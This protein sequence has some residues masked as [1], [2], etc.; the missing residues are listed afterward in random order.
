MGTKL[1]NQITLGVFCI[2]LFGFLLIGAWKL[3]R[4][5]WQYQ[6]KDLVQQVVREMVV[7]K[8][9]YETK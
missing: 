7:R 9:L 1:F 6:K 2:A 8:C 3:N 5:I 4:Y